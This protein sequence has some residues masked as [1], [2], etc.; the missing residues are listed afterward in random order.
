M[1]VL[2]ALVLSAAAA[3][4][5][6]PALPATIP[7]PRIV[8]LKARR[9]L[10]LYT[11]ETLLKTYRVGLGLNPVPPKRRSGD[12]ATP[13]GAYV[14]CIKNPRSQFLLSLGLSYPNAQDADRGLEGRLITRSQHRRIRR[15][16]ALSAC[17]PWDTPL[18]GEIFIHGRG[19][20]SDWT[21]GC[22]VLDD[23]DIRELYS[24]I[25]VGT[26]VLIEP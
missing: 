21:W 16:L 22:V 12:H 1:P 3:A 9:E 25:P 19:S 23:P 13:E 20:S 14:V 11:G 2:L 6:A 17:P 26:P 5:P 15:A 10:R 8:V 18:G 24:R 4:T 7:E